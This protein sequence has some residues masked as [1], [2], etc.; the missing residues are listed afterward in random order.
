MTKCYQCN[1]SNTKLYDP[2]DSMISRG[3]K[4]C[5]HCLRE[6]VLHIHDLLKDVGGLN[7]VM[8]KIVGGNE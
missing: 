6:M 4:F 3:D 1:A 5:V 2:L 7:I 8:N